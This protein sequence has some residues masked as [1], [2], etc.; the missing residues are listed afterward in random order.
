MTPTSY[1]KYYQSKQKEAPKLAVKG[2]PGPSSP[3]LI[4]PPFLTW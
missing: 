2:G 3:P 1:S 4:L